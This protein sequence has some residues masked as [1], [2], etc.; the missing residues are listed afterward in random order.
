M[1]KEVLRTNEKTL[2]SSV[3]FKKA[4]S[5]KGLAN[6]VSARPPTEDLYFEEDKYSEKDAHPEQEGYVPDNQ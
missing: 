2:K 6:F 5:Q 4:S 1:L 3:G